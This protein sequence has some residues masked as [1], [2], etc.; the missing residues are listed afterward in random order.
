MLTPS[1][2]R[3]ERRVAVSFESHKSSRVTDGKPL[4]PEPQ[5]YF[6]F[7]FSCQFNGVRLSFCASPAD[8]GADEAVWAGVEVELGEGG[9]GGG[10]V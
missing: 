7:C 8:T 5:T 4:L 3:W 2:G 6:S 1:S 10:G 9:E